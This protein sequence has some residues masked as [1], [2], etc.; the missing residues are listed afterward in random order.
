MRALL[1]Y[2]ALYKRHKWMLTL[3]VVLAILTLLASIGLLT[4]SGWF[5]SASAVA[6]FAG[7]YSFNYMLPAA[8][9]RGTAIARTAGR[10]FERLVSHDATFRVLQHLRIFTFSKLLPLS[11]AGLA[12]FRQGDLLNRVVAD[13]DT[14]D[15]LYLRVISPLVGAFVVIVVVTLGLCMLDV[16]IALTLGGIMLLTLLLLPPLFYR[17]GK[18]TGE[19]LTRLRGDYRQQLT[20]WLQGQAELTIFGASRRYRARMESTELSWHEAQRRQSE[21]TALSQALMLLIGGFAVIAMLW[22]AAGGVG[23]NTQPGALIALF[24]FCALAAFEALAPVTGAFQH[25]GQVIASAVRITQIVEQTPEV[26]FK[27]S[28]SVVPDSVAVQLTEVTFAYE[29]QTQNALDGI[30]LTVQAG[31]HV[32]IL[33]RTG[34][35]KSTLLQLLTRAWDPRQGQILFN[36]T[37]LT[38]FNEQTLRKIVSVVPQRVH[39]FSATL[40]DNLLLASPTASDEALCDVLEQVGLHKLLEDDGLNAWLGEGGRQL[41]GGELRRLAV[42]RALLHDAP[43][44]LLDEPTE[45]LD[46]TTES[47]ILDLLAQTMKN[48][49]VLM[50]THRLRGLA[51]FDQIIVMDNGRIIE[52]GSH[53]ELFAKQGRYYQF[54]QRL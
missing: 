28:H 47:Q 5:L 15:H 11:P 29:G 36:T 52:Q 51:N 34:C 32:A 3:G 13:V 24:V 1:P 20:S 7:L 33:G 12:R 38:D 37:P 16:P 4:L 44:M 45:G 21:L 41:S 14:L 19:K 25:L 8:G 48:K 26:Q 39:L 23:G 22:M 42:A 10:Y 6:G 53:A 31:Q 49:T 30:N 17:A 18:A 27:E 35:G 40:R 2:L 54:K 43:F 46:A 9:V 50:V